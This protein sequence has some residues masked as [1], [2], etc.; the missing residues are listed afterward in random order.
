LVWMNKTTRFTEEMVSLGKS[1]C[2]DSDETVAPEGGG[3]F[4]VYAMISLR[5][6]RIF[7]DKT[8]KMIIDRLEVIPP[9]LEIIGL[10]L[11]DPT[12]RHCLVKPV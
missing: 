8:Y 2:D 12:F 9:T 6:L 3:S 10:K 11:E 5:R 4:A 1:Y 7:L